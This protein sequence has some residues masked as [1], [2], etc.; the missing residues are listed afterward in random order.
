LVCANN[1]AAAFPDRFPLTPGH[2]LIVPHRH[3]ADFFALAPEEQ[4]AVWDLV[5]PV[6]RA[7]DTEY[8]P[9][10]FNVGLNIGAAAGQTVPHAHLHVIPRY[11]GDV[12]DPRGGIRWIIPAKARYWD[13]P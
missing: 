13:S 11:P 9:A 5:E 7:L 2:T 10:G 3:E 12:P 1:L 8:R 4:Q 6:R